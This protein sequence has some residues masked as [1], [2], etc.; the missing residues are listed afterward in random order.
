MG[1]S[2]SGDFGIGRSSETNIP[3]IL[4]VV[5]QLSDE[6]CDGAR[7]ILIHQKLHLAR[8]KTRSLSIKSAA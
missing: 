2:M 1:L 3:H 5:P 6:G 8:V 4:R 7:Q